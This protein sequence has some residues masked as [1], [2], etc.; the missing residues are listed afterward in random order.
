MMRMMKMIIMKRKTW[1]MV[2]TWKRKKKRSLRTELIMRK[3]QMRMMR[4]TGLMRTR[5][6]TR[7]NNKIMTL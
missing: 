1:T 7:M 5:M 3:T 2:I 4:I 6:K